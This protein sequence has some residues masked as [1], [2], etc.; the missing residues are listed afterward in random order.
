[1]AAIYQ[2][3]A[4]NR[5]SNSTSYPIYPTEGGAIVP[6]VDAPQ[7]FIQLMVGAS[8]SVIVQNKAGV[9]RYYPLMLAGSL[10]PAVGMRVVSSAVIDGNP[11]S[12][13]ATNIWW[14]G[15]E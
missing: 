15:G 12:T 14:F 7:L 8:G 9:N 10:Y 5:N 6:D 1:M 2:T 13:T 4:I 11:V 3:H